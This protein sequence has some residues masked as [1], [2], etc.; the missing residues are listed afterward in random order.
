M[1][2]TLSTLITRSATMTVLTAPHSLSLPSMLPWPLF[3]LG[4]QQLDADPHQ[5]QRTDELQV[6]DCQQ[7]QRE[8]D[9]DDA[10]D[11]GAGRAPDDAL[12]S[13]RGG[14]LRQASAM[15]TALSPPSRMSIMM[16]WPTA[17]QKSAA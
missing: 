13:L 16:I 11:D 12:G 9:Q 15:T 17:I 10:Q 5:Q 7:L 6:R 14:N 2:I 3:V 4:Q 1:A 8:E